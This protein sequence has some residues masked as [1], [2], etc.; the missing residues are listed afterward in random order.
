[1]SLWNLLRRTRALLAAGGWAVLALAPAWAGEARVE[2]WN[3]VSR[4]CGRCGSQESITYK[5]FD[6]RVLWTA[7]AHYDANGNWLHNVNTAA[8]APATGGWEDTWRSYAG[9]L[10]SEFWYGR[11]VG[12]HWAY[13]AGVVHPLRSTEARDCNLGVHRSPAAFRSDPACAM[14][15][16]APIRARDR[17]AAPAP[18]PF[19]PT[20]TVS[21][22]VPLARPLP[23]ADPALG[24]PVG[25]LSVVSIDDLPPWMRARAGQHLR[26]VA[27]GYECVPTAVVS[28]T[29]EAIGR[30]LQRGG[31]AVAGDSPGL[32]PLRST[33]LAD[34]KFLGNL[35]GMHAADQTVIAT[36]VFERS[37]GV[38]LTLEE[39]HYKR[40]PGGAVVRIRELSNV[41]VGSHAATLW[42]Q[43]TTDGLSATRLHWTTDEAHYTLVLLDDVDHPRQPQWDRPWLLHLAASLPT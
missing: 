22:L 30:V 21:P 29:Y 43:R 6:H 3:L 15:L 26:T 28:D 2:G 34:W 12:Y 37:D 25:Q 42:V 41:R 13:D 40:S 31:H 38:P 8:K 1:M 7:S 16:A 14:P 36:R 4:S 33:P 9:H 5:F 24:I 10:G 32:L 17:G 18:V 39:F 11:V 27:A 19:A 20:D 35:P 23:G